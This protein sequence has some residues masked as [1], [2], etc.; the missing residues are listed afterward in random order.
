MSGQKPIHLCYYSNRCQ[1]SRAFITEVGQTPWKGLFHYVC[2]D[3]SPSR[4]PLPAWLKKVPTIVLAGD[5]E[6]KTDSDVM[7]WL[8]EKKMKE[9][10]AIKNNASVQP[11]AAAGGEPDPWNTMEQS[12]FSKGFSY[13]G[14]DVDTSTQGNGGTTIPGAFSFLHGGA[15]SGDRSETNINN[16]N[17]SGR[18]KSKKE[19]LFDKQLEMYQRERTTSTP[20]GPPRAR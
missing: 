13:S 9:T 15:S 4:P 18:K 19:E 16:M 20:Q 6:P 3:P 2:V 5:P 10:N 12:S 11:A 17:E 7:N 14:L 8:Y 1:W